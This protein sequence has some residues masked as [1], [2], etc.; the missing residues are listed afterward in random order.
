LHIRSLFI[1]LQPKS[2][3]KKLSFKNL[4]E[5]N[6]EIATRPIFPCPYPCIYEKPNIMKN[7]LL[8]IIVTFAFT[9]NSLAQKYGNFT[10]VPFALSLFPPISTN[11]ANAGNCVNQSSL[12]LI[13]GYSAGL[14]GVEFGGLT[15]TERDFM[16]GAQIAGVANF[17]RGEATG[18]QFSGFANVNRGSSSGFQFAGFANMN[19]DQADGVL[20]S[21]FMNYINGKSLALQFAGVANYCRDIEGT[22]AAGFVNIAKGDGKATQLGG[23]ANITRGNVNGLQIAGFLNFSK[24]KMQ[25]VQAAGA[26]NIA[27]NDVDG[28]Q[29]AGLVNTTKGNLDGVQ[30]SGLVNTARKVNGLQVGIINVAD[31]IESGIP[32]G[33]VSIVKKGGFQEIEISVGEALNAQ[34]AFK[35]GIERFYTIWALGAKVF[36]PDYAWGLGFGI[37]THLKKTELSS[38]QLELISYQ[39]NENNFRTHPENNFSQAKVVFGRKLS[40][41]LEV[42][43]GPTVNLL[44]SDNRDKHGNPFESHLAPYEL[45]IH[46]GSHS[47]LRG[48]IGF[49]AGIRIN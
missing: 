36:G 45:A 41:S 17:V 25:Y 44:I 21:G 30:I 46:R 35:I 1:T 38:T 40:H 29:V 18:F 12:N 32:I 3:K 23:F 9:A 31:T 27:Q 24:E 6:Q 16:H 47:T 14:A 37:G 13:S 5:N 8:L 48:W 4:A 15:N 33:L 22:Q 2:W 11:G 10:K 49:S 20:A 42:F 26:I 19:Y 7:I 28:V 34:V 39:I 43:G